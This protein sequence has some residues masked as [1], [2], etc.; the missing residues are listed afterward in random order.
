MHEYVPAAS[1]PP[2]VVAGPARKR[3]V[4]S[5]PPSR[6]RLLAPLGASAAASL[7]PPHSLSGPSL[8]FSLP[9]LGFVASLP[10]CGGKATEILL[11]P[12]SR[13]AAR[14]NA[15]ATVNHHPAELTLAAGKA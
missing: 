12:R 5:P 14:R 10:A 4:R 7:P 11:A 3:A 9:R 2:G 8:H 15:L 1:L 6:A 13:A